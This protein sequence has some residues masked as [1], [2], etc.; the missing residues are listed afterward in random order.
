MIEFSD[1]VRRILR[2][3]LEQP[4]QYLSM[5]TLAEKIQ[6]SRRTIFRELDGLDELRAP[7]GVQLVSR[8]GKGI[9][10]EGDDESRARLFESLSGTSHQASSKEDRR[11]LLLYDLLSRPEGTKLSV[12]AYR[13]QV[14]EAT[15]SNDLEALRPWLARFNLQAGRSGRLSGSEKDIRRAMSELIHESIEP[16]PIEYLNAQSLFDDLFQTD[17]ET[18]IM[19]LLNQRILHEV[20]ETFEEHQE[21]L[22]LNRYEQTSYISLIIHLVIAIERIEKDE[23]ILGEVDQSLDLTEA[24]KLAGVLEESFDL[25]FPPAEIGFI[26]L[27]LEG[28][29]RSSLAVP[30]KNEKSDDKEDDFLLQT[31]R[32]ICAA[33]GEP[34]GSLLSSDSQYMQGL[35]AHLEPTL[36]R[37]KAGI[38]IHNP[39]L[40][41]LRQDYQDLFE[42]SR[43]AA[44][45]L[46]PYAFTTISEDEIG[47][48]TIH[49]GAAVERLAQRNKQRKV[50]TGVL[51]ASGIGTSAMMKA[52]LERT[53]PDRMVIQTLSFSQLDDLPDLSL[54]ISSYPLTDM[55]IPV[56]QV[57]PM[58]TSQ[59]LNAVEQML[60]LISQKPVVPKKEGREN[61]RSRMKETARW[62]QDCLEIEES[63][64]MIP[65]RS[66]STIAD[67]IEQAANH[68][69]SQNDLVAQALQRRESLG[70]VISHDEGFGLLHASAAGLDGLEYFVLIPDGETFISPE[71]EDITFMAVSLMPDTATTL[72]REVLSALN[73]GLVT[74]EDWLEA[75]KTHHSSR[76]VSLLEELLET[77]SPANR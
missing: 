40:N 52:R 60:D 12:R 32:K 26:A 64:A 61:F 55:T 62:S 43:T 23:A 1:R 50:P 14:S 59:D 54:L 31:A 22:Q 38:P 53:F 67:L 66:D 44:K 13:F 21:E 9:R 17:Q 29:R 35:V 15:V 56:V 6:V 57:S 24:K 33:Y 77:V 46:E 20:L 49:A 10:L 45:V 27:H 7:L 51:C 2:V 63:F 69:R 71:L 73:S 3:L 8:P 36:V 19:K 48:L 76:A 5:E 42:R 74:N 25:K 30:G 4:D 28:A 70:S 47:F 16:A 75:L 34:L 37:L 18:G 72:D 39:L 41:R 68:S 65:V 11:R 58:L